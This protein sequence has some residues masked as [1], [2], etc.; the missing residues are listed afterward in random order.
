MTG[1]VLAGMCEYL[2]QG[3]LEVSDSC[4]IGLC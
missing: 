4:A 1:R 3:S 2:Q